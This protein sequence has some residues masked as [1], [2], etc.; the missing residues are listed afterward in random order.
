[1][2][3]RQLQ[4]LGRRVRAFRLQRVVSLR[5]LAR[6]TG[7]S[8]SLLSLVENGKARPSDAAVERIEV[9]LGLP[10]G[11]LLLLAH[12][13]RTSLDVLRLIPAAAVERFLDRPGK[14]VEVP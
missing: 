1:M 12:L 13:E 5:D 10:G 11:E 4:P 8:R 9:A 14:P 7:L 2:T 3:P 6:L